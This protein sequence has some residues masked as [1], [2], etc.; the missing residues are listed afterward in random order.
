M[1]TRPY[2]GVFAPNLQI[3][4]WRKRRGEE[5]AALPPPPRPA[6]YRGWAWLAE[7]LTPIQSLILSLL[8]PLHDTYN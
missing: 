7:P 5:T 8:S 3:V 2:E 4:T 6:W 1:I